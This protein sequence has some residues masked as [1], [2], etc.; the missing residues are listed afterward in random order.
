MISI[1]DKNVKNKLSWYTNGFCLNKRIHSKYYS[2]DNSV[3]MK[4]DVNESTN[5][6][7]LKE[8]ID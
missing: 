1:R 2:F 4:I 5:Q 3:V 7:K 8:I 6:I